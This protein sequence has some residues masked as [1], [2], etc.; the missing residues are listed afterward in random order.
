MLFKKLPFNAVA[1]EVLITAFLHIMPSGHS[2]LIQTL[3]K[4]IIAISWIQCYLLGSLSD[5]ELQ[6]RH[7][8][9]FSPFEPCC[10][11]KIPYLKFACIFYSPIL[12]SKAPKQKQLRTHVS[13]RKH[14]PT[15][16]LIGHKSSICDINWNNLKYYFFWPQEVGSCH[17]TPIP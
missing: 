3:S 8:K 6:D 15:C 12:A 10:G 1:S 13:Y 17:R 14:M 5:V 16:F 9:P 7:G 2:M 11:L 4:L